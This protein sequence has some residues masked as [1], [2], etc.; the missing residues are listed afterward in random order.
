M[1]SP[2][3][4]NLVRGIIWLYSQNKRKEIPASEL[5]IKKIFLREIARQI[6]CPHISRNCH[7]NASLLLD[8][9]VSSE[10]FGMWYW[11]NYAIQP[12]MKK[13]SHPQLSHEGFNLSTKDMEFCGLFAEKIRASM[14]IELERIGNLITI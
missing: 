2:K 8:L 13:F 4:F 6:A 12:W 1:L 14:D 10:V 7:R 11:E 9:F 5:T 3:S